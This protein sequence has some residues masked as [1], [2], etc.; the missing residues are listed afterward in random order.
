MRLVQHHQLISQNH[1][2]LAA[3]KTELH[4][5]QKRLFHNLPGCCGA[6]LAEMHGK[7][8]ID[9]IMIKFNSHTRRSSL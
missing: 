9:S 8:L 4:R 6:R 1:I 7:P 3:Q 2:A 5:N